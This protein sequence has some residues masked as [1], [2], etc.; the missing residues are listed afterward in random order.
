M[1]RVPKANR[2]RRGPA[3]A[4]GVMALPVIVYLCHMARWCDAC[5]QQLPHGDAPADVV[6]L[7]EPTDADHDSVLPSG[8]KK[9][10]AE[11]KLLM[12]F[13]AVVLAWAAFVGL[14]R[15]VTPDGSIDQEV[16]ADTEAARIERAVSEAL[17]EAAAERQAEADAAAERAALA[18]Q[19][20]AETA[21][22][23]D[24]ADL[25]QAGDRDSDEFAIGTDRP[26]AAMSMPALRLRR[27]LD[28]RDARP[29]V[30]Y[31]SRQGVVLIDLAGGTS[32][33]QAVE[34]DT[35]VAEAGAHVLRSGADSFSID[36]ATLEV[37]RVGQDSS[38][39]VADTVDGN[40]Y[41]VDAK[42]LSGQASIV[43]VVSDGEYGFHRMPAGGFQLLAVDGLGLLAV[44]KGP[45]GETLIA[46]TDTFVPFSPNRVLTGTATAVLEQ[47]CST[48]ESCALVL[49]DLEDFEPTPVPAN[50]VRFG[51]RYLV[52]PDG[53]SL[54][55][56]S[57]E[58]FAEVFVASTGSIAWVVGAGMRA[59]AWGPNSHFIAWI[60]RI[61][62]PKL[63]VMF[64]DERDW[65]SIDL[66]DLGA[67]P[68]V[69]DELIVF[70]PTLPVE[71][72]ET[73]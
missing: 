1:F 25:E 13:G 55:R 73:G 54:L 60:D 12:A 9:A 37:R 18:E 68:P 31:E 21:A 63:K 50:F 20:A 49:T 33:V 65:L 26:T 64:P 4:V 67:P 48:E 17:Q 34:T 7:G 42:E 71:P 24:G 51:D 3:R 14:G 61:G 30:A 6:W 69:S 23:G 15:I 28:R 72:A 8:T 70:A 44:P 5:G 22:D 29:F 32:V 45:T 16:A 66:A 11:K 40:T 56:Y 59:P 35:G 47:V 27:Q 2:C 46:V 58:G 10:G 39:V 36:P 41:F 19:A 62:E 57:P 52:A 53:G 38:L 43:E